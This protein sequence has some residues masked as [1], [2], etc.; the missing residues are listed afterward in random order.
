MRMDIEFLYSLKTI[1][2]DEALRLA[3]PGGAAHSDADY[4][5]DRMEPLRVV[6]DASGAVLEGTDALRH[7]AG[8]GRPM[9]CAIYEPKPIAAPK[10]KAKAKPRERFVPKPKE[11]PVM[12][13]VDPDSDDYTF[14]E[15]VA[16]VDAHLGLKGQKNMAGL[17]RNI[18]RGLKYGMD[19]MF[20]QSRTVTIREALDA[21]DKAGADSLHADMSAAK[22]VRKTDPSLPVAPTA[23]AIAV[24]RIEG[25][26]DPAAAGIAAVRARG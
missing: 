24:A 8:V 20:D 4:C 15:L 3:G 7:I 17:G 13:D 21:I 6:L 22:R 10:P 19:A 16:A 26:A 11:K 23:A 12:P 18:A 9:E 25:M 5:P 2:P 14:K 1:E